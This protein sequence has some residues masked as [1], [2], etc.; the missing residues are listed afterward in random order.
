MKEEYFLNQD[1]NC[2]QIPTRFSESLLVKNYL[3]EFKTQEQKELALYNLGVLAKLEQLKSIIDAK[4]IDAGAVTW[5][6][7]PTE[8]H[9]ESTLSS[10]AIYRLLQNY[11]TSQEVQEQILQLYHRFV[12]EQ[13]KVDDE[14]TD[15]SHAITGRAINA[16]I[17]SVL[18]QLQTNIQQIIGLSQDGQDVNTINGLR[19]SI[20]NISE[21]IQQIQETIDNYN[22]EGG[23]SE[24]QLQPIIDQLNDISQQTNQLLEY[25]NTTLQNDIQQL[26]NN[27]NQLSQ[28]QTTSE[29][30][31][32]QLLQYKTTSQNKI[33]ELE[34]RQNLQHIMLTE[35]E[36]EALETYNNNILY[37][38]Y[39]DEWKF[40]D[41]FPIILT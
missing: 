25:K 28:Q 2:V 8:G 34:N 20:T 7:A 1:H 5:D 37:L 17:N 29:N 31:I 30:N 19:N 12:E 9:T 32:Q 10:D 6:S 27:T 11:Y 36:Y 14:L 24:E 40:G 18:D 35:S 23:I 13:V 15:T 22:N 4:V 38:V 39:E 21:Q 3:N 41:E 33:Q 16:A 26:Q